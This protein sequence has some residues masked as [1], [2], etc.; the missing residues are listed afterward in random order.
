MKIA[1][2]TL[3]IGGD[4]A[5]EVLHPAKQGLLQAFSVYIDTLFVYS[6]TPFM[7]LITGM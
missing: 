3:G 5:A 4:V 1:I 6:A 2:L 7:I